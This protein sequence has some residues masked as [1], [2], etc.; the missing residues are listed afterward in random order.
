MST[1]PK[2]NYPAGSWQGPLLCF[3]PRLKF[4]TGGDPDLLVAP[5][6][7]SAHENQV[8]EQPAPA[9]SLQ[10]GIPWPQD[11]VPTLEVTTKAT[12]YHEQRALADQ[13]K[14]GGEEEGW[15]PR[16]PRCSSEA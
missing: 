5:L 12:T 7:P 3:L 15:I 9:P 4:L 13:G 2:S 1:C 14:G 11:E 16:T 8:R 6:M 10:D